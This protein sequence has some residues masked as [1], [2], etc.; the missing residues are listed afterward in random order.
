MRKRRENVSGIF[1]RRH[2]LSSWNDTAACSFVWVKEKG[3]KKRR[4]KAC[5]DEN[6]FPDRP[7]TKFG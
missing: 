3:D 7:A 5:S 6:R 4:F 1:F 2:N